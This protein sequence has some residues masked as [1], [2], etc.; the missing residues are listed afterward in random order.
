[1]SSA[2]FVNG[3]LRLDAGMRDRVAQAAGRDAKSPG[4]AFRP[5]GAAKRN[6]AS[7]EVRAAAARWVAP[8]L[9]RVR[10]LAQA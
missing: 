4:R 5:D 1:M 7:A 10:A 9:E 2:D 8:A 3:L 6:R